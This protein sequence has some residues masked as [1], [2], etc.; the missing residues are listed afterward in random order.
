MILTTQQALLTIAVM[1]VTTIL[2]RALPFI[3]FPADKKT[4][5]FIVYLGEVLPYAIIGML[6]VY[7]FKEVSMVSAPHGIPELIA[8]VFVVLIHKW[9]HNLLISIG[10][11]TLLYM[12]LVQVVFK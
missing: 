12:F 5:K 7:C 6:I 10:G 1:V 4:P 11:G 3:I 8:S 2:T 9:K